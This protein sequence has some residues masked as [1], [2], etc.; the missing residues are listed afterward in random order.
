MM[1]AGFLR[2]SIKNH[3]IESPMADIINL[4]KKRKTKVRAEKEIKASEN[5]VKFGRTKQEKQINAQE[6]E[7]N[8]LHLDGHKLDK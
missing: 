1:Y 6:N 5:R 2:Y 3:A 7:R 4:N 8:K